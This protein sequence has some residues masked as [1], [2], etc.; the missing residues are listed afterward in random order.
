M[1]A[2]N[3]RHWYTV[4]VEIATVECPVRPT[5]NADQ[6]FIPPR[7]ILKRQKRP[8][9]QNDVTVY[10]RNSESV[11]FDRDVRSRSDQRDDR[12]GHKNDLA[13]GTRVWPC[14]RVTDH[15]ATHLGGR[16]DTAAITRCSTEWQSLTIDHPNPSDLNCQLAPA[17]PPLR[18]RGLHHNRLCRRSFARQ[19]QVALVEVVIEC[20][21][22]DVSNLGFIAFHCGQ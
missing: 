6:G 20:R 3:T 4:A 8:G 15:R 13:D 18:L 1:F 2:W 12:R 5:N 19:Q 9:I 17:A 16:T 21:V 14:R 10:P 22:D 7:R 11:R